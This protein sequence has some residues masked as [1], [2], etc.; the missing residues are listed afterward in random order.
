MCSKFCPWPC[1][2]QPWAATRPLHV[3]AGVNENG[4]PAEVRLRAPAIVRVRCR[5]R[6]GLH[7]HTVGGPHFARPGAP[8]ARRAPAR[9]AQSRPAVRSHDY[10]LQQQSGRGRTWRPVGDGGTACSLH[11]CGPRAQLICPDVPIGTGKS[12]RWRYRQAYGQ[13]RS[14][15]INLCRILCTSYFI[16]CVTLA[17]VLRRYMGVSWC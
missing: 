3:A 5:D 4:L 14:T 8:P 6:S 17:L 13:V 2:P 12:Q 16:R 9:W 1:C 15:S 10:S 7:A 11:S